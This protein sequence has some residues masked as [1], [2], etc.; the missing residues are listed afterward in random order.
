[1]ALSDG[2]EALKRY[3]KEGTEYY[4]LRLVEKQDDDKKSYLHFEIE[5]PLLSK[6]KCMSKD[7][8][9]VDMLERFE[10][11]GI[12]SWMVIGWGCVVF[13]Y[14]FIVYTLLRFQ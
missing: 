3:M 14:G 4:E 1:M 8:N 6:E 13:L 10:K 9:K 7:F 2:I 12:T 11:V 5:D